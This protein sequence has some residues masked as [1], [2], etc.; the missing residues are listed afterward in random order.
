MLLHPGL[1]LLVVVEDRGS[2]AGRLPADMLLCPGLDLYSQLTYFGLVLWAG[3]LEQ[4]L[5]GLQVPPSPPLPS[6][7]APGGPPVPPRPPST[8]SGEEL[9]Q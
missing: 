4:E 3:E 2:A 8:T 9:E 5:Q 1:D 7:P 6:H